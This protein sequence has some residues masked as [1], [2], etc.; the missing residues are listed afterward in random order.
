MRYNFRFSFTDGD[1]IAALRNTIIPKR[2]V[3]GTPWYQVL[4]NT[5]YSNAFMYVGAFVDQRHKIIEDGLPDS[6]GDEDD[7]SDSINKIKC[8]Q[9]DLVMILLNLAYIPD[10][11]V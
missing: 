6:N 10:T 5:K 11:V 9:S 2:S 3:V 4:S 8:E 7:L 1:T